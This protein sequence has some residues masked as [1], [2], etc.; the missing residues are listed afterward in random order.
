[1][2][3]YYYE[4][5]Y[6]KLNNLEN[7][8]EEEVKLFKKERLK[9]QRYKI[10]KM[11]HEKYLKRIEDI[12]NSSLDEEEKKKII[13]KMNKHRNAQNL[14]RVRLRKHDPPILISK[15]KKIKEE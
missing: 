15:K 12:R 10:S 8:T 13:E 5:K 14:F 9:K 3:H 1:M 4:K 2:Y 7:K 11:Q 6:K